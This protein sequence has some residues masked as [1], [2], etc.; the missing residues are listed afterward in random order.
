MNSS[1]NKTIAMTA[2][3]AMITEMIQS[4]CLTQLLTTAPTNSVT[5]DDNDNGD[6]N[7]IQNLHIQ[8]TLATKQ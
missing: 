4:D 1:V 8:S 6:V 7:K 5:E 2:T 3:V